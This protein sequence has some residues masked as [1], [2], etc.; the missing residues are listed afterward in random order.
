MELDWEQFQTL[1]PYIDNIW[2][3]QKKGE[4]KNGRVDDYYLCRLWRPQSKSKGAGKKNKPMTVAKECSMKMKISMYYLQDC[5]IPD[6]VKIT[7]YGDCE[8]HNHTLK[9]SDRF[10]RNSKLRKLAG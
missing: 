4:V 9:E 7:R 10:K 2:S 3:R 8:E 1:W 5:A 6:R